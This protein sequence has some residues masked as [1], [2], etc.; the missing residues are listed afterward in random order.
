VTIPVF[1]PEQIAEI[2]GCGID[3]LNDIPNFPP[4]VAR[5]NQDGDAVTGYRVADYAEWCQSLGDASKFE[6]RKLISATEAAEILGTDIAHV[7]QMTLRPM[8][9]FDPLC[10]RPIYIGGEAAVF[11]LQEI[12]AFRDKRALMEQMAGGS[13]H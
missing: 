9:R 4:L 1:S 3:A 7:V 11:V 8:P 6:S 5:T 2:L 10:P 12:E 13:V